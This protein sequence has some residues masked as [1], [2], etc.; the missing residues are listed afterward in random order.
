M[1]VKI[2]KPA[3]IV[4]SQ[5]PSKRRLMKRPAK[6]DAAAVAQSTTAQIKILSSLLG[7]ERLMKSRRERQLR[8]RGKEPN[9]NIMVEYL[10][11]EEM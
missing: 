6:L 8:M 7:Q 5:A 1:L 4:P 9:T 11:Y 3:V 10:R 2:M